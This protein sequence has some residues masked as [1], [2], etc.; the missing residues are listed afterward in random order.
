MFGRD[1]LSL[2]LHWHY[3]PRGCSVSPHCD[4]VRKLGSHLCYFN[5]EEDWDPSWGGQT[6]LL[7]FMRE[8]SSWHGVRTL[9]C[10]EGGYRK[11]FVVVIEDKLHSIV[12]AGIDVLRGK[13]RARF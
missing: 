13:K 3:A 12:H 4:A 10:P 11:V 6:L 2:T 1:S 7:D 5:T 8:D 9:Q